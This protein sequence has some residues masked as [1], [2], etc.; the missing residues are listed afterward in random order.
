VAPDH[1]HLVSLHEITS[2][3]LHRKTHD[4][5]T[6]GPGRVFES[7][8]PGRHAIAAKTDPH[9]QAKER[10]IHSVGVLLNQRRAAGD[11]DVLVL[12]VTRAQVHEFEAALDDATKAC[13]A[14][15]LSKDLVKTPTAEIWHRLIEDGV[16]PQRPAGAR[17]GA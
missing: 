11:F 1:T 6:D 8:A 9:E 15:R 14:A 13:V 10:F 16:V 7:A 12:A 17:P 5:V 4:M 2:P 3:D